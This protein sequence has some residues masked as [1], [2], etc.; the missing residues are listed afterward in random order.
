MLSLYF[1]QNFSQ[2]REFVTVIDASRNEVGRNNLINR[3]NVL[4]GKINYNWVNLSNDTF[5]V[6][7]KYTFLA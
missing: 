7:C 5:K 4:N 2:R 3:F 6:K 1:Q